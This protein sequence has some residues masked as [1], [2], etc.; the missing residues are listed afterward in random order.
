MLAHF[1][2]LVHPNPRS[3]LVVGFGAGITAGTF[4][5]YPGVERIVI[6]EIEPLIPPNVG[7]F[8][9]RENLDVLDDPR[10]EIVYDDARHYVLTSRE[11]FDVITS[12]PIHP[13]VKGSATLYTREYYALVKR[14]LNP[15]GVIAEW[16]PLYESREEAVTSEVATFL[17]VFPAGTLW[18]SR[19]SAG[20]GYD[21][22]LLGQDG[23][24]TIDV[25]ALQRRV[26]RPEYLRVIRSL[27]E[28]GFGSMLDLFSTYVGD[29][30]SMASAPRGARAHPHRD[31]RRRY[32][33]GGARAD[34]VARARRGRPGG[35]L[36]RT[37]W[38]FAAAAASCRE[39]TSPGR[40]RSSF[41]RR[42]RAS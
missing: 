39:A 40:P 11:R 9:R 15:G 23:P 38:P 28:S 42:R 1:P 14:L 33:P 29:R 31:P 32:P 8:F 19:P 16:V 36:R 22:I 20:G 25:D 24:T 10:V 27:V 30:A 17:D 41:R 3:V 6:C 35:S 34:Q 13:W 21:L 7:P 37:T 4:L 5:L 26:V 12:D 2:A 18:G